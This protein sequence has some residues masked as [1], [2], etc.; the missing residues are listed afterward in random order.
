MS[1][2]DDSARNRTPLPSPI[3]VWLSRTPA[4]VTCTVV[5]E[6]ESTSTLD[7][8]SRSIRGA[9]AEM[10]GYLISR[11]YTPIGSWDV[12]ADTDNGSGGRVAVESARRFKL[13]VIEFERA[14]VPAE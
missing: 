4:G 9:Q 2:F 3:E 7:V 11:G 14:Q 12:E 8:S 5:L 13:T 10:T 1:I 6:D